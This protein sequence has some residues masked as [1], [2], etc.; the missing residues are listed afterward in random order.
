VIEELASDR[1][2]AEDLQPLRELEGIVGPRAKALT[3]HGT[4]WRRAPRM[5]RGSVMIG[6]L[7]SAGDDEPAAAQR[8]V[9]RSV[10]TNGSLDHRAVGL[11]ADLTAGLF[12]AALRAGRGLSALRCWFAEADSRTVADW[13]PGAEW[14]GCQ[15]LRRIRFTGPGGLLNYRHKI[16]AEAAD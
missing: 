16:N 7:V 6:L 2:A 3:W 13:R 14:P 9:W 15:A 1:V 5:A 4:A 8:V 11:Q 12:A 10:T